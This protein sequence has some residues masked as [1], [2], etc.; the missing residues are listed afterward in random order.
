MTSPPNPSR[1]SAIRTVAG[2]SL[3]AATPI[4]AQ[5]TKSVS[6]SRSPTVAQVVDMSTG[7][8]DVSKD[9]LVGSRAAWQ[10]ING[11]GGLQGSPVKHLVLEVNGSLADIRTA[12]EALKA[13]PLCVAI[14]GTAGDLAASQLAGIL[15]RELPDVP[16][17]AP[18]LQNVEAVAS[19]NTFTVFASRQDQIAH[20]IKSL[21]S[22]GMTEVG[23]IYGSAAEYAA[24]RSDLEQ[25][26][27]ALKLSV[28]SYAPA[29][30]LREVALLLTP[31]SPRVLLFVG[32]TP[33]LV[34]FAQGV[35]KQ[36]A[37]RYIIAM[38]DVN[39]QSIQQ[40][41]V[42]S[43]FTPIIATQVVPLVNSSLPIV[44]AYRA[45]LGRLYD[46]PPT[47]LS[48]AGYMSARFTYEVLQGM[49]GPVNRQNALQAFARRNPVD[50]GGFRIVPDGRNRGTA[51]VTQSMITVDGRLLG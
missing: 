9:F 2:M 34:R 41:G 18:W 23:A 47:P 7:Q 51:F 39:L 35:D 1:R 8:I 44:R 29:S 13:E 22:V 43:R 48:L 20:A 19:P 16:H 49:D 5:S 32:G 36:A 30:D 14:F 17:V 15:G 3:V 40:M 25:I 24:Y 11:R 6:T 27:K 33:E 45:A 4:W 37:Q 42:V 21:S 26:G 28:K 12:V 50:L 38:S 10:E 46:E 31:D